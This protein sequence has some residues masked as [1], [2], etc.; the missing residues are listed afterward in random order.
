MPTT[1]QVPSTDPTDLLFNTQKLDQVVNGSDQ[2][3]TDRLGV[4]RRTMEGISA[5]ADV[6]L[7][8]I[9]YAPPVAYAAG[10]SMT[11]T[12]QT[13]EYSGEVYA[14]KAGNLPF[15]TSGTFETA[16]FRLIQGVAATDLAASDG[17]AMV[18]YMP[19][20]AGAV[21]TTVQSKLREISFSP[22]DFGAVGN[23]DGTT[24][25]NDSPAFQLSINSGDV[26]NLVPGK[27]YLLSSAVTVSSRKIINGNGATITVGTNAAFNP[28]APIEIYNVNF[29][30]TASGTNKGLAVNAQANGLDGTIIQ[31]CKF[32]RVQIALFDSNVSDATANNKTIRILNN[33]FTGDYTGM[34]GLD[35]NNIVSVRG[36][37]DIFIEGN[38]F[39]VIGV[40]RF[41]K[42]SDSCRR[43]FIRGNAFKCLSTS[44]GKQAID[45]FADT[46]EVVIADNIVDLS[47]FSAFVE[48]KNGDNNVDYAEPAEMSVNCNI[49]KMTG[50]ITT[51]SPIAIF[52]AWGLTEQTLARSTTKVFSNEILQTGTGATAAT[53]VVRGMTHAEVSGN[54]LWR[55]DNPDYAGGIEVSNCKREIVFGNQIEHGNILVNLNAAH[56]G[57]TTYANPPLDVLI[58]NNQIVSFGALDGVYI[59]GISR[60]TD[61]VAINGNS[62]NPKSGT[63]SSGVIWVSGAT[64]T[65]LSVLG[66]HGKSLTTAD[67]IV[68]NSGVVTT[69]RI[70]GNSWQG[71]STTATPG[72]ITAG[73]TYTI[74]VTVPGAKVGDVVQVGLP[75]DMQGANIESRVAADNNVRILIRNQTAGS[76][77]FSSGT[78]SARTARG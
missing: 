72:T 48:N 70:S 31:G 46:R 44:V 68:T 61:R 59:S 69:P 16:K 21:P 71:G 53:I 27:N 64:I 26:V 58:A 10:I 42:I 19:A 74:N 8:G 17:S 51:M 20:G 14:P 2:Y 47:G 52:G 4:N 73:S 23:W 32:G 9:G 63:S 3:Y 12:T 30:S 45:L 29:Q 54:T 18:G 35:V 78:F 7:G 25:T 11:L 13:V 75:Y 67:V 41:V 49:I 65:D 66:N 55:D 22:E 5:A 6:V 50:A 28:T 38:N 56:P 43:V 34:P 62:F 60:T 76:L 77:T 39:N 37:V 36:A 1:N 24:G 33:T 40:E 15:T 57:G